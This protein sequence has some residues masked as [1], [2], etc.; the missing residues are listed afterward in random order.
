MAEALTPDAAIRPG[1]PSEGFPLNVKTSPVLGRNECNKRSFGKIS[2][3]Q[4]KQNK[5][6]DINVIDKPPFSCLNRGWK[7]RKTAFMKG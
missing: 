6:K 5:G 2:I 1:P 7:A 3:Q 4:V